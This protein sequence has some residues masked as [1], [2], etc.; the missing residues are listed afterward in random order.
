MRNIRKKIS[1]VALAAVGATIS[2]AQ[3]QVD[4]AAAMMQAMQQY[5]IGTLVP[6]MLQAGQ[7]DMLNM[8]LAGRQDYD[9]QY[10]SWSALWVTVPNSDPTGYGVYY[11]RKELELETLPEE[12][13]VYVTADN[14]YKLYVNGTLVSIGP[15]RSDIR[16][17]RYSTIDLKPYLRE[18]KNV[19]AAQ[20]WNTG[21]DRPLA[22]FSERTGFLMMGMGAASVFNTNSSWLCT[23][24]KG[25]QPL[26]VD[27][28]GSAYYVAGPGE[29]VDFNKC[30]TD[31]YAE[32]CNTGGWQKA[33]GISLGAPHATQEGNG[34]ISRL[35]V[36]NPLP[37]MELT[38][39]RLQ[40]VRKVAGTQIKI[41]K[42][43]PQTLSKV[44]VPAHSDVQLL[45]DNGVLTN[46]YMNLNFNGGK[47]ASMKL[48]YSESGV[49]DIQ[50]LHK[51]NRNEIDNLVFTGRCDSIMSNGN[52][53]QQFTTLEW[54]TYRYVTLNIHTAEEPL[55]IND[56]EGTF[57]G[58]PFN[59]KAE[60]T[61]DKELEKIFETGWRTARL[62]AYETYMDCP[63]YEQLQYLGDTRIQ[64]LITL[65]N[66]GDLTMVRNYL[67]QS[68]M[69]RD[70]EG[71]T[72]SRYPSAQAQ[73]IQPYALSYIYAMHDY[74]MY[75]QDRE[76]LA[77]L[78]PGAEGILHYFRRYQLQD[79]RISHLPGWNFS[80]WVE[81]PG[82]ANGVALAGKDGCSSLMDLQLL[83]A[84]QMMIDLEKS[85]GHQEKANEYAKAAKQLS[86]AIE[87]VYWNAEKGLYSNRAE[88]DFYSQHAGALALL[89]GLKQGE[90][91][92]QMGK[93]LLADETLSPCSVYYKYYLHE[94]LV[95]AGLGEQYLQW[96]DIWRENL[97]MGLTTWAETSNLQTTRSDCHAWG[98]SPNI[99]LFRTV[100][101][102]DSDEAGF[103]KVR[104]TPRLSCLKADKKGV[105][106][107]AGRMPHPQGEITVDY[108]IDKKGKL[109]AQ[110]TI[111]TGVTGTFCWNGEEKHLSEGKN[112]VLID[113]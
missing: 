19:V 33:K 29:V 75:S 104:I 30:L 31:W 55:I 17:W 37:E 83:L 109:T 90:E 21:A 36:N 111:P 110:V 56:I 13:P 96:L 93:K 51:V 101:G 100:L 40:Q 70:S 88:Q 12:M 62:C 99:E 20:V 8:V 61:G 34:G 81:A 80:D 3:E 11:F 84:Y 103:A 14:R 41:A 91:A 107:I 108:T 53:N 44:E 10:E 92:L 49:K 64:A 5:P 87:K 112:E 105:R 22:I 45:L 102:I 27:G 97:T 16:H 39:Q 69:S 32:T 54:R 59:L 42:G 77:D 106:H 85:F 48:T 113:N 95:K 67:V 98:A 4:A 46:A 74:L 73:Y 58:Y 6:F 23:T 25:S 71:V 38:P 65:Y 76:T 50:T 89:C 15:S 47:G 28:L 66:T 79:G 26:P 63:Y 43:W 9:P 68:D 24:E 52:D 82:W 78:L 72:Q 60:I 7:D 1:I 2:V 35:L 86:E 57:T 18:G 94:A